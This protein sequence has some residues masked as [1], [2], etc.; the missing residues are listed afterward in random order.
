MSPFN[1]EGHNRQEDNR[2]KSIAR[3]RLTSALAQEALR[4]RE[5]LTG[6]IARID[7]EKFR[8]ASVDDIWNALLRHQNLTALQLEIERQTGAYPEF[9]TLVNVSRSR[10]EREQRARLEEA[11]NPTCRQQSSRLPMRDHRTAALRYLGATV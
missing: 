5:I 9:Q 8:F 11:K 7:D 6:V 4:I 3:N 1:S 10:V 2:L